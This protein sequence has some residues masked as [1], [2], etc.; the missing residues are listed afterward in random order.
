MTCRYLT[1]PL[2]FSLSGCALLPFN[3]DRDVTAEYLA[4]RNGWGWGRA[5]A[6]DE[7]QEEARVEV[8]NAQAIAIDS[9]RLSDDLVLGMDMNDVRS[10]WGAPREVQT[11]GDPRHGNQRW[12]YPNGLY[13]AAGVGSARVVY[14]E[15]GRVAGWET[16]QR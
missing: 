11:A 9:A 14:F 13:S 10:V 2:V 3:S 15:A 5:P 12:I 6:N 1:I 16:W 8:R 4:D 7:E